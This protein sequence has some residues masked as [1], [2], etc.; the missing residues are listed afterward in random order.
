MKR[1][2]TLFTALFSLCMFINVNGQATLPFSYDGGKPTSVTGLTHF[3]LGGDYSSSPKMKF[4]TQGDYL[5]LNFTG[6]PGTLSFNIKWNQSTA[7]DRFPGDFEL[8]ESS[9]GTSY[10]RVQIYNSNT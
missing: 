9:D 2:F 8:L 6:S 4:D 3:G 7:A 10:T 5:V 1:Y